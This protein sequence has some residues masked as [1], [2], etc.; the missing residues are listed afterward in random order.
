MSIVKTN[1]KKIEALEA[2]DVRRIFTRSVNIWLKENERDL[3]EQPSK[4]LIAGIV[5]ELT[6]IWTDAIEIMVDSAVDTVLPVM[7]G[8]LL[9]DEDDDGDDDGE[10]DEIEDEVE[11]DE[12]DPDVIDA[13]V[14]DE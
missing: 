8:D 13:E 1:R 2:D 10:D 4:D 14:V 6:A 12:K 11:D 3:A 5:T 9:E 7:L